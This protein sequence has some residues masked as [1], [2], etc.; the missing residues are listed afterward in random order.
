ME[1]DEELRELYRE[2]LLDYYRDATHKGKL[3]PADIVSEGLNPLC[4]DQLTFTATVEGGKVSAVR[5]TGHGCVISQSSAALMAEALEGL[6]EA[7]AMR[8]A[9]DF[10]ACMLGKKDFKELPDAREELRSL[11]GVTKFP[12]RVKCA[13]LA[14]NTLIEGLKT[15]EQGKHEAA[16][17]QEQG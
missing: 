3:E 4:G 6:S 13:T 7:E 11:Q 17:F 1:G 8:L 15:L 10:K 9:Q 2:T 5:F 14:W 16:Q 12:V